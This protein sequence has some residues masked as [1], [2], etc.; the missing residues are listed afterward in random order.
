MLKYGGF[1]VT[2]FYYHYR[3][4]STTVSN[5][6]WQELISFRCSYLAEVT[7]KLI[8]VWG[9]EFFQSRKAL[10]DNFDVRPQPKSYFC[11]GSEILYVHNWSLNILDVVDSSKPFPLPKMEMISLINVQHC[12]MWVSRLWKSIYHVLRLTSTGRLVEDWGG[13]QDSR[14]SFELSFGTFGVEKTDV[15][16]SSVENKNNPD[17]Q[18]AWRGQLYTNM[19][20]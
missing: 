11:D 9:L 14:S 15:T 7:G 8:I 2:G 4:G 1:P 20:Y 5:I 16:V 10:F 18:C 19:K 3:M 6:V 13:F 17:V 12:S